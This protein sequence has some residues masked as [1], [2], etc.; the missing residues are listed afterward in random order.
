M[1]FQE[2]ITTFFDAYV[3]AFAR[4]DADAISALWEPVG[5][6]PTPN[7]NFAMDASTFRDH[8]ATLLQFYRDQGVVRPE[9][10]LLTAVALYPDVAQ[11]RMAYRMFGKGDELIA[12]WE[13]IYLLRR[14]DRWRVTLTIADPE[15]AAWRARGVEI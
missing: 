9:G 12:E 15:M 13:H 10:E 1:N 7:G 2:E 4:E 8:C 3:D 6:F 11:A 14:S 5:L